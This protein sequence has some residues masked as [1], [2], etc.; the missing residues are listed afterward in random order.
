MFNVP[1]NFQR[2][3]ARRTSPALAFSAVLYPL[4]RGRS[5]RTRFPGRFARGPVGLTTFRNTNIRAGRSLSLHRRI[6][7]SAWIPARRESTG[8]LPLRKG[9]DLKQRLIAGSASRC[10][11]EFAYAAPVRSSP[12][13][14]PLCRW[15]LRLSLAGRP[16][17]SGGYVSV[18]FTPQDCSRRM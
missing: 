8:P 14:S 2:D 17:V 12:C 3:F 11:R 16:T 1:N 5:L 9:F 18:S 4:E 15:E 7:M 13:P 6:V 10:L